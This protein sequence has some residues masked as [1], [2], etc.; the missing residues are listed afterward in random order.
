MQ[1]R[2]ILSDPEAMVRCAVMGLGVAFAPMPHVLAHLKSGALIRLLPDWHADVG[3]IQLYFAGTRLLPAK[4]RA[5]VDF[6]VAQFQ[7]KGFAKK[8]SAL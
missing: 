1:P 5:F 4:T 8:F 3:S 6:V 7:R 2:V